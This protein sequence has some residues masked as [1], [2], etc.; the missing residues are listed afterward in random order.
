[1]WQMA[2]DE[3]LLYTRGSVDFFGTYPGMYVPRPHKVSI[4]STDQSPRFLAA[5]LLAL[6]KMN[7]NNT[8]FDGGMPITL[9]AARDVG[10]VLK[11]VAAGDFIDARYS[12]Y[13]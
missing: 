3:L 4:C 1:M 6:T 2:S 7:W 10:A 13:M 9:R 12:A 8:Q 11:Y 5:E